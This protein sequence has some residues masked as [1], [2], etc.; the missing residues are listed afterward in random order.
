M[1]KLTNNELQK[2]DNEMNMLKGCINRMCVT[3]D[4]LECKVMY[5]SALN[6]LLNIY[7]I[8]DKRFIENGDLF[9][10]GDDE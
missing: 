10:R 3:K 8:C 4:T 9:K 7:E 5:E 2:V 1:R 6:R